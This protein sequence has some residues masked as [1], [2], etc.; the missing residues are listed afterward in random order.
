MT[1]GNSRFE[2]IQQG[3]GRNKEYMGKKV[4]VCLAALLLA[5]S[6]AG[7]G[8]AVTEEDGQENAEA[9]ELD[10]DAQESDDNEEEAGILGESAADAQIDFAMLQEKNPDIFAWLHIPGTGIDMPVL[11]S[12]VSDEYYITHDVMG[13]ENSTGALYTEMPNL[14]NMCDFNTVIH[15]DD[16]SEDAPFKPL[17][18]FEDADFFDKHEEFYLYLPDNVLTYEIFAAYYDEGSDIL[19]R[20]D[21][22]T[23]AGCEQHLQDIY[24]IRS[25]NRNIREE[26]EE[27]TPYH[28]LVTLDGRVREDGRQYVVIGAL[29]KD[30]AGQIDRVIYE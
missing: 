19:R 26:W 27:L 22:T 28:F 17:H 15:G 18:N 14:M 9:P 16:L 21:Y 7:C 8:T 25:M 2:M 30:A 29:V 20:Y 3:I 24:T 1:F 10:T 12:H 5:A 13:E 6:M 4:P 11:Q 23:Y